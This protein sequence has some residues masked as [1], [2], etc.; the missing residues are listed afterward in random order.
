VAAAEV[1]VVEG[2][3]EVEEAVE[4]ADAVAHVI[5]TIR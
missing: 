3:L 1:D 4:G 5:A 2:M